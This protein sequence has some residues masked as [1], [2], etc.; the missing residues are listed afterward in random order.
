MGEGAADSEKPNPEGLLFAV[1]QGGSH[2]KCS[3]LHRYFS[4]LKM[5]RWAELIFQT[6]LA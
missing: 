6:T 4:V 1:A 2:R 5:E 3:G